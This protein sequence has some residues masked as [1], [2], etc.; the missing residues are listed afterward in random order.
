MPGED[1]A[2]LTP[3]PTKADKFGTICGNL[4]IYLPYHPGEA[5]NAATRLRDLES[6][7]PLLD[8]SRREHPLFVENSKVPVSASRVHQLFRKMLAYAIG[9]IEADKH[10][11]RITLACQCLAAGM[12]EPQILAICRW[13]S[14]EMGARMGAQDYANILTAGSA[15]ITAVTTSQIPELDASH[16][17]NLF[18]TQRLS[19]E[20][21]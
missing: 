2:I 17:A 3:A 18:L 11:F 7:W 14:T 4:P 21:A 9:Q 15:D 16:T 6:A 19:V 20:V 13:Q 5:I 12:S 10:S 8:T 1:Y